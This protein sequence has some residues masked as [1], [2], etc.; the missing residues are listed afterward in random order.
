[1]K[2]LFFSWLMLSI[3]EDWFD[4]AGSAVFVNLMQGISEK[5]EVMRRPFYALS[6]WAPTACAVILRAE[7]H[8]PYGTFWSLRPPELSRSLR[9]KSALKQ[10]SAWA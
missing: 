6:V 1:M 10:T 2:H 8:T 4:P 7:E 5:I 9:C 3:W